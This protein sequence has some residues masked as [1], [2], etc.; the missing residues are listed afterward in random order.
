MVGRWRSG[1]PLCVAP[2]WADYQ[3]IMKDW[4]DCFELSLRKPRDSK[5]QQRLADF[6]LMLTNFRYGDDLDGSNPR[7]ILVA[8]GNLTG[9]AYVEL[10]TQ[11]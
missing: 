1:I 10:P 9:I 8:Q 6:A 3:Q 11:G 4:G 5:E 7:E 2:T